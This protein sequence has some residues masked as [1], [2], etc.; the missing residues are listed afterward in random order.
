MSRL[1]I[2]NLT[3]ADQ[4]TASGYNVVVIDNATRSTASVTP[5]SQSL[6]QSSRR[7]FQA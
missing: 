3:F 6:T 2:N 5:R 7:R 4:A 1:T